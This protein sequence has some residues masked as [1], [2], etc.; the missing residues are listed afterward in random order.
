MVEGK[1]GRGIK[2]KKKKKKP[3]SQEAVPEVPETGGE[4]LEN[5]M[6]CTRYLST[7]RKGYR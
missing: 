7:L 5:G 4:E 6:A 2:R 1:V 3:A